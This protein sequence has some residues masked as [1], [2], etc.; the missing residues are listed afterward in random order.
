MKNKINKSPIVDIKYLNIPNICFSLT[1]KDDDREIEYS[2]QRQIRGFDDS[3]TWSLTDTICHFVLPRL[4][5]FKEINGGTPTQL[6]EEEWRIILDKMDIA[7]RLTCRDKGSR[8][9]NKDESKQIEEGLDLF[10][11]WF[12]A[13]WW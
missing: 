4:E 11:E 10:R 13:L 8:I 3:E 6:T 1:N 5:R 12:M 7:F 2:E 9:W